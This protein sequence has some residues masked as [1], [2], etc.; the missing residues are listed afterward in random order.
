MLKTLKRRQA[1]LIALLAKAAREERDALLG[2]IAEKELGEP[3][4]GRGEHN[5]TA[6]LAFE[7]LPSNAPQ[8]AAL[9]D[10][11]VRLPT[12]ARD[13]LYAVMRIGEGQYAAKDWER[14]V[15]EAELMTSDTINSSLVD[16]VDLYDHIEKGLYQ[17]RLAA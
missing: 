15:A 2:N 10:A 5:P 12:S 11:I 1:R 13:E 7:P 6:A 3:K 8:V 14:V 4:P 9:R 17:L 16:D